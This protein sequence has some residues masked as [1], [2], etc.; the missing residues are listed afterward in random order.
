MRTKSYEGIFESRGASYNAATRYCPH[1]RESER[2]QLIEMLDLR[3]G[4][5]VVD[6]PAGGGYLAEG[7]VARE[8]LAQVVCIEP[9]LAFSR[10]V[11]RTFPLTIAPL[12]S[13]PLADACADRVGSLAGI[14]H[15]EDKQAMFDAVFRVLK[16]GGVFAVAD[17]KAGSAVAHFLDDAVDR[18][19]ETGHAGMFLKEGELSGLLENAGFRVMEDR[20]RPCPWRFEGIEQMG[21]FCKLL[22]GLVRAS[23]DEVIGEIGK[24]LAVDEGDA[25]V[26]MEW[27]LIYAA[28][29]KPV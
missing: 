29:V 12:V 21:T 4:A 3:P 10:A 23:V 17:V 26:E 14:H 11:A 22:F 28:G 8:P 18:L 6:I 27:G 5:V 19:S 16:P 13:I 15:L 20:Y 7:I 25:G 24:A 9:S 2:R 1:A